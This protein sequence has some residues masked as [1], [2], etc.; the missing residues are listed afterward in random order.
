MVST[1]ACELRRD[2][3]RAA[4]GGHD[5]FEFVADAPGDVLIV[6]PLGDDVK[7][8]SSAADYTEAAVDSYT[9][10]QPSVA[11]LR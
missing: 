7:G 11:I 3:V 1:E 9:S 2:D 4:F 8:H 10:L 6:S 5:V